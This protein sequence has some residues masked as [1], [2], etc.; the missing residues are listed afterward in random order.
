MYSSLRHSILGPPEERCRE[1]P[2]WEEGTV[3][4]PPVANGKGWG[5]GEKCEYRCPEGAIKSL[6]V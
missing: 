4:C 2:K 5:I 3:M 6:K 1:L